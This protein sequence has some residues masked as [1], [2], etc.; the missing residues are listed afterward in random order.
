VG[1]GDKDSIEEGNG[2]V[3]DGGN[4]I[5]GGSIGEG[6]KDLRCMDKGIRLVAEMEVMVGG[7]GGSDNGSEAWRTGDGSGGESGDGK[8]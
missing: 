5:G 3:G 4:G 2:L 1:G 6:S 8:L 7:S